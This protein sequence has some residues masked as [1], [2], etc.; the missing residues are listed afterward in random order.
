MAYAESRRAGAVRLLSLRASRPQRFARG[1]SG[2][3][4]VQ[5]RTTTGIDVSIPGYFRQ[6]FA[7]SVS[8]SV[9]QYFH[10]FAGT[11]GEFCHFREKL[12]ARGCWRGECGT[13]MPQ[14]KRP[15]PRWHETT[16]RDPALTLPME[17]DLGVE[18]DVG[19]TVERV[20]RLRQVWSAVV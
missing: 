18:I 2:S 9:T 7:N 15:V 4:S 14:K 19:L 6:R 11:L 16:L 17:V 20:L 13:C 10:V 12:H 8:I 3:C 1:M 5:C